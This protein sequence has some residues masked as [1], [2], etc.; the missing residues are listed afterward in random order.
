MNPSSHPNRPAVGD[1]L[2]LNPTP[3]AHLVALRAGISVAV[4]LLTVIAIGHTEWA[5][6]AAF[7]AFTSLYGRDRL[8]RARAVM[9][10][11]A[12]AALVLSVMLG[13][14]VAA[15]GGPSAWL[16]V[17]GGAFVAA[18][19]SM[20]SDA[21]DWHPPGPLFV[22]FGFGAVASAAGEWSDLPIALAVSLASALFAVLVGNIGAYVRQ[23]TSRKPDR[24]RAVSATN[25][26]R[27]VVAVGAAGS[28]A[29]LVGVGY[30]YWAMVAAAAPLSV[31]GLSHQLLRAGHRIGGTALGLATATPLLLLEMSPVPLVLT[32]V[33]LQTVTEMLVGRN[34]GLALVFITPMALLMGQLG[35]A[36]PSTDL[37]F[38]RG[39]ET[40]IG[41]VIAV[42][43]L[44]VELGRAR[45]AELD[46][47]P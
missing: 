44:L 37:L 9:Q 38:D 32:I 8:H 34:Y 22:I 16:I 31:R 3:G 29:T 2:R 27:Y 47:S 25:A 30:P 33:V 11:V 39:V 24:P 5:L 21:Q 46:H 35:S 4:P 20:V 41:V 18:A 36:Q 12:G 17:V 15:A 13:A 45:R 6:Y 43:M 19:F 26:L 14:V 42:V 1:F 40:A 7:G 10:I 23:Q 28:I